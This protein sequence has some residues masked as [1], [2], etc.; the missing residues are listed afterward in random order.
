MVKDRSGFRDKFLLK[1]S[2]E[3]GAK[4]DLA[5]ECGSM[6]FC[7]FNTG[8]Y[9]T[10]RINDGSNCYLHTKKLSGYEQMNDNVDERC[11]SYYKK[12]SLGK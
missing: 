9:V 5:D 7:D 1:S 11:S 3:C 8:N 6:V 4:C 12:C 10:E 2:E